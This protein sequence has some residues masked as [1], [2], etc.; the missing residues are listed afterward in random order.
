MANK[1]TGI[2]AREQWLTLAAHLIESRVF[3]RV[4][5]PAFVQPFRISCGFAKGRRKARSTVFSRTCSRDGVNEIFIS[6]EIDDSVQVLT[7]LALALLSALDDAQ[8]ARSGPVRTWARNIGFTGPLA[9]LDPEIDDKLTTQ[10]TAI[11]QALGD[12]PHAA[13]QDLPKQPT[14]LVKIQCNNAERGC[15][16]VWRAS[17]KWAVQTRQCFVCGTQDVTVDP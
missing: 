1:Q 11:A 5:V 12:Y 16:A 14:R 10:L 6:P 4:H 3:R 2:E 13:L 9:V 8:H 15:G 17:M 7:H